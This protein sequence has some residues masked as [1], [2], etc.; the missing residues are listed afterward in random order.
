MKDFMILFYKIVRFIPRLLIRFLYV[1]IYHLF[2]LFPRNQKIW[3]FTGRVDVFYSDNS[4]IFSEY[5]IKNYPEIKVIWISKNKNAAEYQ[6]SIGLK[7]FCSKSLIAMFYTMRAGKIFSTDGICFFKGFTKNIEHYNLWHGMPLKKIGKDDKITSSIPSNVKLRLL[8]KINSYLNNNVFLWL[9][10]YGNSKSKKNYMDIS[11]DFFSP[12]LE[13]AFELKE[14]QMIPCGLPRNDALFSHKKENLLEE[15]RLRY[16]GCKIILYMPT[17]RQVKKTKQSFDPFV[18]EYEFDKEMFLKLLE[19]K[20]LVFIHKPHPCDL[21][22]LN[23]F[24]KND[25]YITVGNE[26]FDELYNFI[27][28]TDLLITDYSSIYFDFIITQKP[29][30]LA[31][32]DMEDYITNS[33]KLYFD[34]SEMQAI[35]AHNWKELIEILTNETYA[36][37][38]D[39]IVEKFAKYSD[40]HS[41]EKLMDYIL[42]KD[43]NL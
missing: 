15:I 6:R 34:Y 21:V 1:P 17:F 38:S 41:C 33:R 9:N 28:Q 5:V 11:S 43:R 31:P 16:P 19:D 27:G 13:S 36:P 18:S 7:A 42:K 23:N 29:V 10:C 40:G 8:R 25:R 2:G 30:I 14:E 4:R 35:S 26:D 3:I 37:V 20:N 32:F 24:I 12:F 39:A 22:Y